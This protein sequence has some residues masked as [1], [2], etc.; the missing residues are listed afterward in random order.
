MFLE[1]KI[2]N[3]FKYKGGWILSVELEIFIIYVGKGKMILV[4]DR[5]DL[6]VV[7][8]VWRRDV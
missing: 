6:K 2:K 3:L 7:L 8:V 5:V 1:I 4:W